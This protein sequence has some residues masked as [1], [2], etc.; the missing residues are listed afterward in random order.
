MRSRALLMLL[1][2]VVA[3][4]AAVLVAARW[5]QQ[6]GGD[7]GRI[8]VANVEI[9]LGSRL[10]P[11]MFRL[12]DWPQASVPPGAFKDGSRLEGRVVTSAVHRGEPILDS[13]L[14]PEGSKGAGLGFLTVARDASA[15]LEYSFQPIDTDPVS[16]MFF[17]TATI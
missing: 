13:R 4:L 10:T 2:A 17:L 11:D 3:G 16:T 8:A 7:R 14:A 15:P 9:D 1:I 6:Q 5:M 12:V